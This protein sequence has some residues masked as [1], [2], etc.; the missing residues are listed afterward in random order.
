MG[1]LIIAESEVSINRD[2]L[3]CLNDLHK[4]AVANGMADKDNH[5][6]S[7][8]Q[9]N[10]AE[11][12]EACIRASEKL[13][14]V[15]GGKSGTYASEIIAMKYAGWINPAYEI[16]LYKAVQALKHGDLD[17]AVEL[18]GS[19]K[20]K[21]SLDEMRKAKAINLQLSNTQ[22]IFELLP[23][24]GSA[25]RQTVAA[26][27]VNPIAGFDVIPLPRIEEKFYTTTELAKQLDTT[28]AMLGR[29][30]N[31][32]AMKKPD[33][34]GEFRLSTAI[35]GGKQVEQWYGVTP[36]NDIV[37]ESSSIEGEGGKLDPEAL[38]DG[39]V[40]P[41]EPVQ[42]GPHP[43]Q[44]QNGQQQTQLVQPPL[45]D[46]IRRMVT[47]DEEVPVVGESRRK[48]KLETGEEVYVDW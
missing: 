14:S 1:K 25:S 40:E 22:R 30:A 4:A 29:V 45:R 6:P 26:N 41:N 16:Q 31:G 18:S 10:N 34:Y 37:Q 47:P 28:A 5:R 3:Y 15:K 13:V 33:V 21:T 17:K 36:E 2:G 44:I 46:H 42:S 38:L 35:H 43:L 39:R 7:I 12:V 11:F 48:I 8:F 20:A 24:L 9:R 32:N 23:H 19:I 27:L